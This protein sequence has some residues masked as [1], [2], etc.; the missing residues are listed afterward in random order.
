MMMHKKVFAL[1]LAGGLVTPL[2]ALADNG[3][4]TFY[5]VADLS[6]DMVN[7]GSGTTT[8]NGAT[9]SRA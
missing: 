7:T 5:G 1:A 4:F 8:A 6:Y 2:A 3:N 9:L